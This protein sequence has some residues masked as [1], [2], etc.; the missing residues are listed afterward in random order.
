RKLP[1]RLKAHARAQLHDPRIARAIDNSEGIGSADTRSWKTEICVIQQ[2]EEFAA[3]HNPDFLGYWKALLQRGVYIDAAHP[4]QE[5]PG[6]GAECP[7]RVETHLTRI[8][9]SGDAIYFRPIRR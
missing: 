4:A 3:Q 7:R 9:I 1:R 2:V 8:E 5:V 6:R